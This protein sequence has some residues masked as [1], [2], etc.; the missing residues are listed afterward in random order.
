MTSL[1]PYRQPGLWL[2]A[3]LGIGLFFVDPS[4]GLAS[5]ICCLLGLWGLSHGCAFRRGWGNVTGVL[6]GLLVLWAVASWMWSF[7]PKGTGR[8]VVKALPLVLGVLGIPVV[9]TSRRRVWSGLLIAAGVVTGMLTLELLRLGGELGWGGELFRQARYCQPY[10]YHHPNVSSMMAAL[11]ALIYG[12][13]L[14]SRK[15]AAW[16]MLLLVAG[17]LLCLFYLL[18]MGSRG[19]QAVLAMV[20]LGAPVLFLPGIKARVLALL[21]VTLL[22][23]AGWQML[24]VIN[25]RFKNKAPGER[26]AFNNR[27]IVWDHTANLQKWLDK[28]VLGFGFG[29]KAFEKAYYENDLTRAPHVPV[30]SLYFRHA[31][32]YWRMLRFQ[33]GWIGLSVGVAAWLSLLLR[34]AGWWWRSIVR[35]PCVAWWTEVQRRMLPA[36]LCAM[37]ACILLYGTWDYPDNLIRDAQFFLLALVM[38]VTSWRPD[39]Y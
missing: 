34:S 29:K 22:A 13:F 1:R 18:V 15:Q 28:Q 17:M 2:L 11:A 36:L 25:P 30:D 5:G 19:P 12:A 35:R 6:F 4:S 31:H 9:A 32:S 39:E 24:D 38:A 27:K 33:G 37:L 23:V 10:L 14:L 8:D 26:Y 7:Y 3:C 16:Q 20:A 21:A